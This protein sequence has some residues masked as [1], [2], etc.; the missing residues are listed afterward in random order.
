MEARNSRIMAARPMMRRKTTPITP[1][2]TK[3]APADTVTGA[4]SQ[5]SRMMRTTRM[6]QVIAE[7]AKIWTT[8]VTMCLGA[9]AASLE[10]TGE[11]P[12][13]SPQRSVTAP[14]PTISPWRSESSGLRKAWMRWRGIFMS[15]CTTI[16]TNWKTA[17][18]PYRP[19]T[20]LNYTH[21]EKSKSRKT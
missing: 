1:Q 3:Q 6:V 12:P 7:T 16:S 9:M 4:A 20:L 2:T 14:A 15:I 18:P 17:T 19:L 8:V 21:L 13:C 5:V 10:R 11:S